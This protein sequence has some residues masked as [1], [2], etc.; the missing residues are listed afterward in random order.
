MLHQHMVE[1]LA[2]MRQRERRLEAA[3]ERLALQTEGR[4]IRYRRRRALEAALG[5]LRRTRGP[6][7]PHGA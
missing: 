4:R 1:H 6:A 5:A 2:L 7:Q 3:A